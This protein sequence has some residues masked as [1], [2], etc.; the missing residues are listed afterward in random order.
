MC[1]YV[2]IHFLLLLFS[3]TFKIHTA[4]FIRRIYFDCYF[5]SGPA[6]VLIFTLILIIIIICEIWTKKGKL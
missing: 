4:N 2:S 1:L 5:S 3:L 6:A